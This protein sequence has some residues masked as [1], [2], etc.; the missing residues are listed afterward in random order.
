MNN[1]GFFK[2]IRSKK[3]TF[4]FIPDVTGTFRRFSIPKIFLKAGIVATALVFVAT[5]LFAYQIVTIDQESGE[6][7]DLRSQNNAQNLEIQKFAKRI[8]ELDQQMARLERFDKKLRIITAQEVGSDSEK[9]FG[10]GGPDEPSL[11][12]YTGM[13][14]WDSNH[15][16]MDALTEDLERLQGQ[17]KAQEIS[18]FQLDEFFKNQVSL[19]SSTPSIWPAHGWVTSG[20]GY[21]KSPFTGLREMH[22]GLD[23]VAQYG[24]PVVSPANGIV[25][26][27]T[28]DIG[29]GN[30]IEID[31]G[32]GLVTRYGHN[33]KI[34][35]RVGD[36]VKRGQVISFVG[37]TG[38]STGPHLHYEVV[39]NGVPVNPMN[40]IF[41]EG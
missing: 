16:V 10:S 39:L 7:S 28:R 23:I 2:K 21:R 1:S 34:L 41:E 25:I 17:A 40:Y 37:N 26:Q 30:I 15:S 13:S 24:S 29:Y 33:S 18:F 4:I 20:F 9:N 12:S 32:Y 6:L 35:V 5:F 38:R 36:V 22:E 3:Y 11:E 31:H 27:A 8:K 14:N 19:L